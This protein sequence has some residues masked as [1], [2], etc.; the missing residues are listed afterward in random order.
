MQT[1][2]LGICMRQLHINF[3]ARFEILMTSAKL[4]G[5]SA[6]MYEPAKKQNEFK[7]NRKSKRLRTNK[8]L[9]P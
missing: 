7:I 9:N 2:G 5:S 1:I 8:V 3:P 6:L 4:A